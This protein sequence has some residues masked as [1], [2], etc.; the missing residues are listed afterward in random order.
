MVQLVVVGGYDTLA[1]SSGYVLRGHYL[2]GGG[3]GAYKG[4]KY[5]STKHLRRLLPVCG[6][7][8]HRQFLGFLL[9]LLRLFLSRS[10][11]L[12]NDDPRRL[13]SR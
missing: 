2:C 3:G 10:V 1:E 4:N 12:D 6:S 5:L 13:T 7:S 8:N 11:T 9:L